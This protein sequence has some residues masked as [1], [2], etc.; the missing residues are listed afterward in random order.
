MN[1]LSS[2]FFGVKPEFLQGL[3]QSINAM[4][5]QDGIFAGDNQ[6][7]IGRSLGFL[8]DKVFANAWK[9]HAQTQIEQAIVW[10]NHVQCWA[11]R[12]VLARKIPG[13]FVD[14]GCYKGVSVRI[15]CDC[16]DF[17][18]SGRDYYLYDLFEHDASMIHHAMP[19]HGSGLFDEV[20]KR[21]AGF[22]NVKVIKGFVPEVLDEVAP[23]TIAFL[24][25]DLNNAPAEIGALDRL[26][27]RLSPGGILVLDDYG[28]LAYRAQ[29]VA[30]DSW[31]G[32]RGYQ[33]LE[34]PTGQGLVFK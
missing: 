15:V 25:I 22:P 34:L 5:F 1:F 29:K 24:H 16:V 31:L 21:F 23:A 18:N 27:D 6:F 28:W 11:A 14:C 32:A 9:Q 33:V 17:L 30:E 19:E 3:Q 2:V 26:F 13:D 4:E 10:R 20:K 8:E 7:V 12:S